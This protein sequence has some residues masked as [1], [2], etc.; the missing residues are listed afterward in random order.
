M[1]EFASSVEQQR[2]R[3]LLTVQIQS[4]KVVVVAAGD[5]E[6]QLI[7]KHKSLVIGYQLSE[8]NIRILKAVQHRHLGD[9][10]FALF[11]NANSA[12]E[13]ESDESLVF[14]IS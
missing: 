3:N 2:L 7:T 4:L 5:S 13:R 10:N 1:H 9:V 14:L 12:V 8:S 6:A 11:A